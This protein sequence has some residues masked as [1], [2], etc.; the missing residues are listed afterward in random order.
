MDAWLRSFRWLSRTL[1]HRPSRLTIFD[2]WD[3]WQGLVSAGL[4]VF[5]LFVVGADA[6]EDP[7]A[8]AVVLAT[9]AVLA[10]VGGAGLSWRRYRARRGR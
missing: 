8:R 7:I 6:I 10:I 5:L 2:F 3:I 1:S 4:I 9:L